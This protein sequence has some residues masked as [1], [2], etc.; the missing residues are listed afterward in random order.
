MTLQV[1]QSRKVLFLNSFVQICSNYQGAANSLTS[2]ER[3]DPLSS[4]TGVVTASTAEYVE[5]RH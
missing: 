5:Y 4:A 2:Y 1:D 3:V